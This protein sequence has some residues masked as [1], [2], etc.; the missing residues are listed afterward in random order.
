MKDHWIKDTA[1]S[2]FVFTSAG[3]VYAENSGG[4]VDEN[5]ETVRSERSGKLLDGEKNVLSDGGCVIRLGGL[6]T[7]E[8]GA[9]NYW[10]K[11]GEFPAK[12]NGLINLIHYDDAASSVIK[13]LENPEKV[14]GQIFLV[15]DGVP[16]SRQEI[17]N[18]A[19]ASSKYSGMHSKVKFTGGEDI[20][21][22]KYDSTK[23]RTLLDWKSIY[24]INL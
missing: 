23:I 16:I 20:D 6:Y 1:D 8:S 9:H 18:A 4:T 17:V 11:G 15:S 2:A 22:K 10:L 13:C 14:K 19:G 21:G 3:S 12:P 5:S 7:E 24:E